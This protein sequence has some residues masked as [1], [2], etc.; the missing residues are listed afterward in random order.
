M[1]KEIVKQIPEVQRGSW[2][3]NPSRNTL[4]HI[5]I[6]LIK[7][8]KENTHIH[9][10]TQNNIQEKFHKL[11]NWFKIETLQ[12]RMECR[13]YVKLWKGRIY[14]LQECSTQQNTHWD[15]VRKSKVFQKAEVKRIQHHETSF[16]TN[17]K[18]TSLSRKYKRRKRTTKINLKQFTKW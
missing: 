15:L 8:N 14:N 3:I 4:R 11:I 1:G 6:K 17:V 10:H 13:I 2:R 5:V 18:G 16:S 12:A 9:T 7:S